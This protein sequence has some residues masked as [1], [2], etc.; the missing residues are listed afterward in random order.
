MHISLTTSWADYNAFMKGRLAKEVKERRT[1]KIKV[2]DRT[3]TD[4]RKYCI[5]RF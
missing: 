5:L 3:L 2:L 4:I 1:T